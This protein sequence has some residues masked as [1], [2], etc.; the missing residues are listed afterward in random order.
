MKAQPSKLTLKTGPI[1]AIVLLIIGSA[2]P[3]SAQADPLGT[4][5]N[6][7]MTKILDATDEEERQ[8]SQNLGTAMP[9]GIPEDSKEGILAPPSGNQLKIDGEDYQLAFNSRIRDEGNRIVQ[10]GTI[11][12][13]KRIRYTTNNQN[14]VD[15]I[16]LLAPHEK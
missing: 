6:M 2:A 15:K 3:V 1:A 4:L 9:R 14:Q 16:W 5:V 13:E 8:Q 12:H 7:I 11:R 10:T